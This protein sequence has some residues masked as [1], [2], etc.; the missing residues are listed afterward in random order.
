MESVL[1]GGQHYKA[2]DYRLSKVQLTIFGT[3]PDTQK[4]RSYTMKK[5]IKLQAED[6]A[7]FLRCLSALR[8]ICID[9]DIRGGILRQRSNDKSCIF[10]M[11]FAPL[12]SNADIPM[13]NLEKKINLLR[14]FSKEGVQITADD[15]D[16][17]FSGRHSRFKFKKPPS[18]FMDN[19]FIS[20]D[21]LSKIVAAKDEGLVLQY[22]ITRDISK[23]MKV[24]AGQFNIIAFQI[25]FYGSTAS[26]T[27][28]TAHKLEDCEMEHG[29]PIKKPLKGFSPIVITPFLLD[30]D[31]DMLFK[32]YDVGGSVLFNK[33]TASIGKISVVVYSR[34][35]LMEEEENS[36][37]KEPLIK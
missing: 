33:F 29:I 16:I 11:N 7:N 12:V 10:E 4:E 6:F 24:I 34:S 32:T 17:Y 25:F 31:G 23:F 15:N 5:K 13:S 9:A 36:T 3:I 8:G 2:K 35:P 27:A 26:I 21:E 18:P 19:P 22:T 28:S 1:P 14:A 30:R 20:S 37:S